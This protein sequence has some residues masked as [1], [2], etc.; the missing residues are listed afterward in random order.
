MVRVRMLISEGDGFITPLPSRHKDWCERES[1][2]IEELA[3]I[4]CKETVVSRQ[5]RV[6]AHINLQRLK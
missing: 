5:N 1:R 3:E 4:N 2:K 6:D